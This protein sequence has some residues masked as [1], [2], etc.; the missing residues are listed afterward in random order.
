M[1]LKISVVRSY[2][3]N[4]ASHGHIRSLDKSL[5]WGLWN[6]VHSAAFRS[7]YVAGPDSMITRP[8]WLAFFDSELCIRRVRCGDEFDLEFNWMGVLKLVQWIVGGIGAAGVLTVIFL[9]FDR[10][11][12]QNRVCSLYYFLGE[13][14]QIPITILNTDNN[15]LRINYSAKFERR[16]NFFIF[17]SLQYFFII[18]W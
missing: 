7:G 15:F 14:N 1:F 10:G 16:E 6:K 4:G 11:S 18:I 13:E 12:V 9:R 2:S 3:G 17:K 8:G 5:P